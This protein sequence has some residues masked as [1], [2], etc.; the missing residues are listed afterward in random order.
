MSRK[1]NKILGIAVTV[2]GA[3]FVGLNIIA[4][5][6]KKYS[7]YDNEPEQKNPLEG[8]KVVFVEDDNDPENADGV[9]GHLEATGDSEYKPSFYDK[10]VK[11]GMDIALSFGGLVLL[12]PIYAGI[13]LA[14]KIDD[15]GPVLFTQKRMGQNKQYFKLHKF[16]SMK[17][18]TPHDVPTHMLDNPE[19]YI[20]KVGKFLRAH[21]LDELPQIWD[22]FIGNMSVIGPRPGLWNQDILTA[23]RDK[24]GANDVKPGL[25]GWAQINGRDELEIP[26][27]ARLDGDYVQNM[28]LKMDA[29]C[30]L[31][32]VHVFGKDESV[33]EGGTGEMKKSGR[34]YTEGKTAKELIGHIGFGEPVEVD[35][36]AKKSVLIT[37]AGS[38][39]GEMFESYA[40]EHYTDNFEIDTLD[41]LNP[42]WDEKDFSQYDIVYHVAG[43]AHA[44]VGNVSDE[45]KE[46]Y[47]A[48]N[49]DLTVQ[50]AEK[51]KTEG[52]KEFIFMSSMIVYGE[53]AP[54]GTEKII[55]EYTVPNPANFYGDSKLQ[56][57]VAVRDLADDSFK[58]L[59]LRPPM[60]YGKGSKGNYPTLA[61]LAKKLPVFPNVEN[62]RSMLHIDN[63]CE[64]LCQIMLIK[65]VSENAVVLLPQNKE[66][67]KTADMVQEIAEVSGKHIQL[68][69]VMNPCVA[70]GKNVP[71][72]VSGLVNKAFGNNCY[73]HKL[74]CYPGVEYQRCS[75]KES[76]IRTEGNAR[77]AS[78]DKEDHTGSHKKH[79]LVVSQYFYPEQFRINDMCQ[80]WVKRGYKVTVLTGIPNYPMGKFYDGYGYLKKRRE[81]WNGIDIIRIPLIPRGS[82]S[83]G[84]IAN[85]TSFAISGFMKNLL[86]N[87]EADY[88][89]TF[90]VSPM[91]QALIGC[92]YAKKHRVPHYLY[93]QDLWPEN[94]MTVTGISNPAI[95]KPIDKMVDYIYKNTDEIFATS[96]SFVD[97]I[98]N[99]KAKVQRKKVHYWPQ[100]AEEFYQ[101][102]ECKAVKEIPDDESFK[103]IFTGNI[104]TA[105]GLQILPKTAELLKNENVKFI[106]VGDGRYLEEFEQE[107]KRRNVQ[108][109]FIMIPRQPA[110]RIPELLAAC[111]AAFLSFQ[112][113]ELWTKTIPAKLQSYMACGMPIIA[114]AQGETER[115]IHEA[116]CGV[117][118][119]IGNAEQL[120]DA[121]KDLMTANLSEM[122]SRSRNYFE[123]H[124]DKQM[125]MDQID[126][127]F[128]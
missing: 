49:T 53:S 84:M 66:W 11:R 15:P 43:I 102:L 60:I 20:T 121:I 71:G 89:F 12:S 36:T 57:D 127:Y 31:G 95:I 9:R 27:K 23:E 48:V 30:F 51:A 92:W 29:K 67:T 119:E 75:Q 61:K 62:A 2:S 10:Y 96:P 4:K 70:L 46:K 68:L 47:Y 13:A 3:A 26:D 42:N 105:Q 52:V 108:D 106:M 24:Y 22:I 87:I 116:K 112:N 122:R 107:I 109:Q 98:C 123:E 114:A 113:D 25:T 111:D 94:V 86:S 6:K 103:I 44:D 120:S 115:V 125:L 63:L 117:C 126:K 45:T 73:A 54:Y 41:M 81:V 56:A 85:Y 69:K 74:S 124:F 58:V 91:T 35:R 14:I 28:G 88:L 93:V 101:P 17:M 64:F 90:E 21:S 79:I 16:R 7:V 97:A 38:Y 65:T 82:S 100:Y 1:I 128:K 40:K 72:K 18:S 77:E 32:S 80:E 50:V 33:V 78:S 83:I 59:V 55:D 19:Q 99:R 104:G 37:G 34:K 110:E 76:I 8:K 39:I 118:S 5:N